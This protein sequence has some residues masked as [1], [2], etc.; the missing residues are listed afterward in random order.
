MNT[1]YFINL[2]SFYGAFLMSCGLVAVTFIGFKAKTALMSGGMS[3]LMA[4]CIAYSAYQGFAYA[5]LLGMLLTVFLLG[6]FSWRAT[7]TLFLLLKL[8]GTQHEDVNHKAIAF[9]IIGLM[10]V[11]TLF[12]IALQIVLFY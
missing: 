10:A 1:I 2:F 12:V 4:L 7:K 6:I 8:T 5:Y 3:G 9:L 11:V